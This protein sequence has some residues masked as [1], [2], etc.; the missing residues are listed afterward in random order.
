MVGWALAQYYGDAHHKLYGTNKG[1][2][3]HTSTT[4][5][6]IIWTESQALCIVCALLPTV[7]A[8]V[9]LK[10]LDDGLKMANCSIQD[11]AGGVKESN[12]I[13]AIPHSDR[14]PF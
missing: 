4:T 5:V 9:T 8:T 7:E 14:L 13:V 6:S 12:A 2:C 10:S 1:V 11:L 3:T